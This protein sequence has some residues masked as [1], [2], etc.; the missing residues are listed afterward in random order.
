MTD[1]KILL[2]ED[3]QEDITTC[4]ATATR[5]QKE[6]GRGIEI[7][8]VSK[9]SEARDQLD[10]TFDGAI[11]D[12]RLNGHEEG[13]DVIREIRSRY[14]IP[15]AVMTGTPQDAQADIPYL[16]IFTKGETGY[17]ELL[18]IFCTTFDTGITKI[19]GGHGYLEQTM[20]RIFWTSIIPH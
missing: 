17:D 1:I 11:V 2:V 10:N 8:Q 16:G 3:S 12:L 4:R 13:N 9:Y 5:Y 7:I 19:L 20:D 15:V 14:R 6:R 18:D